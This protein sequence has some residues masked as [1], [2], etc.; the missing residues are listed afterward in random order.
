MADTVFNSLYEVN[1]SGHTEK[2]KSGEE[3]WIVIN[4]MWNKENSILFE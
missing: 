3:N 4:K 1:V 2:K